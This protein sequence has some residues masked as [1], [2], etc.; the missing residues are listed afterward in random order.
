MAG[1]RVAMRLGGAVV[2]QWA[3][4][5]CESW[6]PG[7]DWRQPWRVWARRGR[8]LLVGSVPAS[9]REAPRSVVVPLVGDGAPG[10]A[11]CWSARRVGSE[12]SGGF[13]LT[14]RSA[15][16][17]T[18]RA[19]VG[20]ISAQNHAPTVAHGRRRRAADA[21]VGHNQRFRGCTGSQKHPWPRVFLF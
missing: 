13:G 1:F 3:Q 4:G 21:I 6:R 18:P 2:A 15:D 12:L 9:R 8:K 17:A 20:G 19:N 11:V 7:L 14:E 16:A 5:A 10:W